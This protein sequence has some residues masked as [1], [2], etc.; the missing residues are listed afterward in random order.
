[1]DAEIEEARYPELVETVAFR[2]IQ[3]ALENVRRHAQARRVF[4]RVE[5]EEGWLLG[6][7]R[8]DGKGFDPER[9]TPGLGL[10][11]MREW[12]ELLGGKLFIEPQP[13]RGTRVSFRLPL[14]R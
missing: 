1:M 6:E 2:V 10:S 8:D 3:E 11:G 14:A 5:E 13:G 4:L 12:V 9:T 7:V